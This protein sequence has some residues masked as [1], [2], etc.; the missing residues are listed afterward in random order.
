VATPAEIEAVPVHES[1]RL[2]ICHFLEHRPEP[3]IA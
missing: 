1:I 2:R 3:V